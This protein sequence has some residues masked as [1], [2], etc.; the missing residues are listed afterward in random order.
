ALS[1][2]SVL[3]QN[4]GAAAAESGKGGRIVGGQEASIER[5]PYQVSVRL[6]TN[7]LLHICGGAIY[8]PRV[9]VTAA[10][11]IKGR[12]ASTI[13]IVAGKSSILD[14]DEGYRVSKLIHHSGYNK[15]THANDVG[16]II[17]AENLAYSASVQPIP[18]AL[19]KPNKGETAVV[20]GWGKSDENAAS[21][22]N[23]LHM[24]ELSIVDSEYCNNQYASK[25]YAITEEMICAGVEDASKDS[26]Q[27]DSGGPLVVNGKLVGVVSWG[28]GCAREGFPGVYASVTYHTPWIEENAKLYV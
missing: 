26:C 21:L 15:K 1:Q 4:R 14:D 9:I 25:S 18:L 16:L 10:H 22:T 24:A 2:G 5:L 8:A 27:G 3:P 6:D 17:L 12:F 28:I 11:C 13:R 19:A 7:T 20:S 23:Q